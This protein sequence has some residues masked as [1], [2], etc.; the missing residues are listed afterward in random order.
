MGQAAVLGVLRRPAGRGAAG[1]RQGPLIR[2]A[3]VAHTLG[4]APPLKWP[5]TCAGRW[6]AILG[7]NQFNQF[8]SVGAV[9][10]ANS[11]STCSDADQRNVLSRQMGTVLIQYC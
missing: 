4:E 9:T 7:L 6:C 11:G 1:T 3:H 2:G 8:A 10:S 5:L